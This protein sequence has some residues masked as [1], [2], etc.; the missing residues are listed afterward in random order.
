MWTFFWIFRTHANTY[1]M[2]KKPKKEGKKKNWMT[3]FL[4]VFWLKKGSGYLKKCWTEMLNNFPYNFFL[5]F[6]FNCVIFFPLSRYAIF[7]HFS[8][9][10]M[11]LSFHF[12]R[13][14]FL[15]RF[16]HSNMQVCSKF[17]T[18][19]QF[20]FTILEWHEYERKAWE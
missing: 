1:F 9:G 8:F 15:F 13:M 6:K 3:W 14:P 19:G 12:T 4:C 11:I 20:L 2:M 17:P 18:W 5:F 10:L 7:K 16:N